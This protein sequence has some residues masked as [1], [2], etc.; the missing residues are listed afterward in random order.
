MTRASIPWNVNQ[1][2]KAVA[3]G[4]LVFDNAIQ[5]GYVWDKKRASLLVDSV[6]RGYTI[7]PIYT[8]RTNEKVQTPKGMVSIYDC[9]DGKQRCTTLSK[10]INNEFTLEGLETFVQQDGTEIDLNGKTFAELD[11]DFQDTFKSYGL[12]V[13]Y[14][15]DI[16]DDEI[17]E[18]MSRM[19]NGKPLTGVENA[20]IKA[21]CLDRIIS[22][23]KHPLLTEN[24][25][26]AAVKGYAN[27]DIVM[28]SLLLMSGDSDL[29]SKNV[30]NAYENLD[31][32]ANANKEKAERLY[33]IMTL[34]NE[35]VEDMNERV[36]N[37]ELKKKTVKKVVSKTNLISVIHTIAQFKDFTIEVDYLSEILCEFFGSD[38]GVSVNYAYNEA[39]TNGTMRSVNVEA[40]NSAMT[41]FF[42]GYIGTDKLRD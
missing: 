11:E 18:M 36:K 15:T 3:N 17:A 10:F 5:R 12:S 35:S 34:I 41:N 25:S 42:A 40:R 27:E 16:T 6:L 26:E 33:G 31:L 9:I 23:A 28:K 20:R 1:V 39:C 4:S 29:S 38:D 19:N 30:R 24:L 37:R 2:T 7:P 22:L 32:N 8:I 21:I 14:F 13:N